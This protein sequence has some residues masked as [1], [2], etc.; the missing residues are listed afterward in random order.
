MTVRKVLALFDV[1]GTLTAPRKVCMGLC[2]ARATLA[3]SIV[4]EVG[5][6]GVHDRLNRATSLCLQKV[7]QDMVDELTKLRQVRWTRNGGDQSAW[8]GPAQGS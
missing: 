7:E 3:C 6:G 2:S 1:D 4:F 8:H 5:T